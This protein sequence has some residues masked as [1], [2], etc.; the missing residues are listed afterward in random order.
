[1]LLTRP[2]LLPLFF[3]L[4]P[5]FSFSLCGRQL[6]SYFYVEIV[7]IDSPSTGRC[8]LMTWQMAQRTYPIW[9]YYQYIYA[10]NGQ[11]NGIAKG[12]VKDDDQ[13]SFIYTLSIRLL[14]VTYP[15]AIPSITYPFL[16]FSSVEL[17]KGKVIFLSNL[18]I[19]N[20]FC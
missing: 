5:F 9:G 12:Q 6:E 16:V 13:S 17:F 3:P 4:S 10:V 20:N 8:Q 11:I 18:N 15:F 1:M 7:Y 14:S 2:Y 19:N